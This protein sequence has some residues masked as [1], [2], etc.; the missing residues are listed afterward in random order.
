MYNPTI[1]VANAAFFP[2]EPPE[3]KLSKIRGLGEF[4]LGFPTETLT[5]IYS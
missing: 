5:A 3:T 4:V 1:A 2:N